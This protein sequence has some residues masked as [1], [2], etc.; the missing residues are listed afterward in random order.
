MHAT[1]GLTMNKEKLRH[2][3]IIKIGS[4]V[5]NYAV[6]PKTKALAPPEMFKENILQIMF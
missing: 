4:F 6:I 3:F 5:V 2:N 1:V